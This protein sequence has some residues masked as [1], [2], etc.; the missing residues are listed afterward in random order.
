MD[1]KYR[2]E[3][4]WEGGRDEGGKGT[5]F[6]EKGQVFVCVELLLK[7]ATGQRMR[8]AGAAGRV[9]KREE[10]L[11]ALHA[12]LH[13]HLTDTMATETDQ[14]TSSGWASYRTQMRVRDITVDGEAPGAEHRT[15]L[16]KA[17]LG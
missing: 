3:G 15:G 11:V 16:L 4:K 1:W 9:A 17:Q 6:D 8:I 13:R 12:P 7:L 14:N 10:E 5:Y 2:E